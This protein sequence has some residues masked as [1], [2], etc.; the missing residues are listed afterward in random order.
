MSGRPLVVV[1]VRGGVLPA[2]ALE[3]IAEARSAGD[4]LVVLIG[5]E[6]GTASAAVS[7]VTDRVLLAE[8]GEYAP[9]AWANALAPIAA[10]AAYVLLPA[11]PDGRDLAVRLAAVLDRDLAAGALSV[12][13][14]EVVVAH[15][16]GLV[17]TTLRPTGPFVATLQPNVRG[18]T[19]SGNEGVITS[20]LGIE[21]DP[22]SSV[23]PVLVR[24][25]P[26]EAATMDLA[27]SPRIVGGGAGMM[28]SPN[29]TDTVA[30]RFAQ[31]VDIGSAIGASMGA[32]RVVTDAGWVG[33]DRQIGTTG[34]VVDPDL[35]LAFGIS[36][37]VQHTAGLG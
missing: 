1:P 25:E 18:V 17:Q 10:D 36:G 20:E 12:S 26:P 8:V 28:V 15:H 21:L 6:V 5:S 2:G 29:E 24:L 27:E 31:L 37:A 9:A 16:G 22:A 32:T 35:Y 7:A 14:D 30:R 4:A 19:D 3:S 13:A 11:S 33:H 23:D 34:V